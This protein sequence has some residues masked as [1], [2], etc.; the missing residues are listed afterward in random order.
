MVAPD[1]LWAGVM[2]KSIL[3]RLMTLDLRM[4]G[5]DGFEILKYIRKDSQLCSLKVLVI[6][7]MASADLEKALQY[8]ADDVLA[9][10]FDNNV[11]LQKVSDL[12]SSES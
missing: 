5:V 6:S 3:P 1:A 9:K 10:P 12:L 4:P 8:G 2:L 7:G 11:L